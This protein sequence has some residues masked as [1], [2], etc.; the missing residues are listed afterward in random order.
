MASTLKVMRNSTKPRATRAE[1]CMSLVASANSLAMVEAMVDPESNSDFGKPCA[2][3]MMKVTAMVSPSAR[4]SPSMTAPTAL[5][6]TWGRVT[7]M[8]TSSGVAPRA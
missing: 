4:P 2:L 3:P 6:R 1:V 7:D 8:T 5:R